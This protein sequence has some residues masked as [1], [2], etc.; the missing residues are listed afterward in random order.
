[1]RVSLLTAAFAGLLSIVPV[2]LNPTA[3][4]AQNLPTL[5]DTER[6]DLSPAMERKL[7]DQIMID[8]HRNPD[9][10]DDAQVSEY[11]NSFGHMLVAVRP[12]VRGEAGFDFSFFAVR[13][14]MINAFALPG[15][16]IG[17]HS[18]LIIAAQNE[19]ELAGVLSHEIGHVAQ[20]HI[21]RMLGKQKQ[22]SLIPLA[23]AI[24]AALAA[25]SSGTGDAPAALMMG[26]Q[27]L[28]IQR[29]IDF[30]R[31]AEREA[32]RVGL[33]IMETAGFD[34]S[35]L[36]SFFKRLQSATRIE[37]GEVPSFLQNHPMTTERIADIQGRIRGQHYKQRADSLDFHLIR[38]RLRVIQDDSTQG[39][40][41]AAA[42]FNS[43][44]RQKTSLQT[45]AGKYG[46]A[47]VALRQRR[48]PE[49][50]AFL[51]EAMKS[52]EGIGKSASRTSIFAA[53]KIDIALA[54]ERYDDAVKEA[55][56]ARAAFPLSRGIALQYAEALID[57]KRFDDAVAYLRD[58]AQNYPTDIDVRDYLARAYAALG[59]QA[60]QHMA[61]ADSYAMQGSP[62][63][64][65][66]QLGI[67]RRSPDASY[68]DQ[69][70][71][72]ARERELQAQVRAE[73][74]EKDKRKTR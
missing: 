72:D 7:G 2:G 8:L 31:D 4:I 42:Y 22:D 66:E 57:A 5:G 21:A 32:D 54:A 64:A 3:A 48:Y 63:G 50:E 39:L 20:R 68:Y 55:D 52:A 35:S 58:Q 11:L 40:H 47:L 71:I 10:I 56:D 23:A 25:R 28:A 6:A 44:L 59:K 1:M 17:V 15:G 38:A 34:T 13:D 49:A 67:A 29:Q 46:L 36:I 33:Q 62:Q 74:K 18:G 73:M 43:Q 45:T 70:I 51:K 26:G 16:N 41:N 19:S 69:A 37:E 14:P 27:G 53:T 12:E 9:F 30:T 60:L 24:L 65:L 61:L